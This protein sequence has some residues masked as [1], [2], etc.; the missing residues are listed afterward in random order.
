MWFS[1]LGYVLGMFDG[2]VYGDDEMEW[3]GT[4]NSRL[5]APSLEFLLLLYGWEYLSFIYT[6]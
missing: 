3:D 5:I 6:C 4:K 1:L 2:W